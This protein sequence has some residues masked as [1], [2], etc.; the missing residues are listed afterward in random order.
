[1]ISKALISAKAVWRMFW[2]HVAIL[3]SSS[4][5]GWH[6]IGDLE[7][8]RFGARQLTFSSPEGLYSIVLNEDAQDCIQ[9]IMCGEI[10]FWTIDMK[11]EKENVIRLGGVSN[12]VNDEETY[13]YELTLGA[14]AMISYWGDQKVYRTDCEVVSPH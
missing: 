4:K 3:K 8:A 14:P 5:A 12:I 1:M 11:E 7:T 6:R 10:L 2:S 13:W 9:V